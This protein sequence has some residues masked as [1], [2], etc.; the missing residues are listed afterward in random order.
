[1]EEDDDPFAYDDVEDDP[2]ACDDDD[3]GFG[4]EGV[5]EDGKDDNPFNE[6]K[7][8]TSN[9]EENATLAD[10]NALSLK[11]SFLSSL[12]EISMADLEEAILSPFEASSLILV[13]LFILN[14]SVMV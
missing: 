1:M 2:F 6:E 12:L 11:F 7:D 4:Y 9:T 3:D 8:D 10:T 5:D 13:G 14:N